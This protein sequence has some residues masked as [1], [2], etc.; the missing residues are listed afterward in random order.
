MDK[1]IKEYI[2]VFLISML[3]IVELRGAVPVGVTAGL[4][5]W[6]TY[7]VA[8]VGNML[9]VPVILLLV[10]PV[11]TFM[12]KISFLNKIATFF[13]EKG[14]SIGQKFGDGKYWALFAFVAVPMP[15]TGAWT[16][17]LAAALLDM[18]KGK[19]FIAVFAGVLTAGI[20]MGVVSYGV[21]G[22][23]TALFT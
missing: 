5:F 7:L 12:T 19:S 3:P 1:I 13:L 18:D 9:P 22:A 6:S 23:F 8:A 2:W 16:G 11:L 20:I 10:K 21:L 4:P 14:H 17:S 15:G